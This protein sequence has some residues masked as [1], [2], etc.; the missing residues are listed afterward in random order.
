MIYFIEIVGETPVKIGH[1]SK[2][3]KKRL[4]QLQVSSPKP[5][6]V[7]ATVDGG[8]ATE[9]VIHL[10]FKDD[11]IR[12]EWFQRSD[13]LLEFLEGCSNYEDL[14]ENDD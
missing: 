1:T 12:G 13:D 3:I 11:L 7:I 4:S 2:P 14:D 9:S 8:K 6:R 5:M 10:I